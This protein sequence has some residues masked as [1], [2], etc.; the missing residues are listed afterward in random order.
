MST[1]ELKPCPFCGGHDIRIDNHWSAGRNGETIYSMCCYDCGATFPNRYRREVMVE[2]WNRR[3]LSQ[4]AAKPVAWARK[5]HIDGE[6][7]AKERNE[8]NR[9]VWP[10]K[11]KYLPVTPSKLF[12]DDVALGRMRAQV[13]ATGRTITQSYYTDE[14][15][16]KDAAFIAAANPAAILELIDRLRKAEAASKWQPIETAPKDGTRVMLTVAGYAGSRGPF[17]M[18]DSYQDIL[19]LARY[20]GE[21]WEPY[22]PNE[23]TH[24]KPLPSIPTAPAD[25]DTEGE[26]R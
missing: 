9:L 15:G 2:S 23:W 13:V 5:W 1:A 8:N 10:K 20:T 24:W 25:A 11:F 14:Q 22:I 21:F 6:K 18:P 3:A 12:A 7:P 4:Q 16:E 19:H 17:S 26:K